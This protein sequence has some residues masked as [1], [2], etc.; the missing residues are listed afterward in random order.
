MK[1]GMVGLGRMGGNMVERLRRG[2][3]EV[4]GYSRRH[5]E[6][7]K[8]LEDLV[9]QLPPPK[10]VWVMVPA[11]DPTESTVS[12]L[13]D[14]MNREDLIVDGGNSNFRDSIRR[15]QDLLPKGIHFLDSGT[16]GGIWGLTEGYC[17]MVGGAPEAFKQ[18]EPILQTLA[19]QD[20]YAHV[21][22]PG[23][24]HFVKMIHNGIEYGMMQAYGEGFEILKGSKDFPDLDLGQIAEVWRRGSVVRSW[25]LDLAAHALSGDPGLSTVRGYAEDSGEGRWSVIEAINEDVPAAVISAALFARFASR[26]EE[27]FAMKMVAALRREF[28]GHAVRQVPP[29]PA[30]P[31][32]EELA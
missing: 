16:S 31:K 15:A 8:S 10:V 12:E 25:L 9:G 18:I 29:Q 1:I 30:E 6:E 19:P 27:S 4:V 22:P 21:G 13:A 26:R 2:G 17:L 3:H 20:G 32:S 24:G 11:G 28:G 14:L 5:T 23:A 7:A